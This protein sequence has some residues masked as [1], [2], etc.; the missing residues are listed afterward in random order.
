[1]LG[2]LTLLA[3]DASGQTFLCHTVPTLCFLGTA[4]RAIV[5]RSDAFRI[6]LVL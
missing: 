4:A 2:A 6:L 3:G 5:L 1:M